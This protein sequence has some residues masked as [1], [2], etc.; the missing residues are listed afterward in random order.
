MV[1]LGCPHKT[2]SLMSNLGK[3]QHIGSEAERKALIREVMGAYSEAEAVFRPFSVA[4]A[5]TFLD[6]SAK[7]LQRARAA[8]D[9]A[10]RTGTPI[11]GRS[12]ASIDYIPPEAGGL[13][14]AYRQTELLAF[15]QRYLGGTASSLPSTN[16][17]PG[18][19]TTMR[20]VTGFTEFMTT[21]LPDQTWPFSIQE[22][23]TPLDFYIAMNANLLTG[24]ALRLTLRDFGTLL[25]NAAST[26]YAQQEADDIAGVTRNSV[27][28]EWPDFYAEEFE[29]DG[30][31]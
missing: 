5:C 22:D 16:T 13:A 25:A 8:R 4:E 24:K 11:D 29:D 12:L 15:W 26:R 27:T 20:G 9:E 7:T 14:F 19:T 30:E 21:G 28:E 17:A 10:L 2:Q 23:G 1:T 3:R 31:E 18:S 6:R